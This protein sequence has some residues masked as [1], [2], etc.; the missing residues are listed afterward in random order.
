MKNYLT[1]LFERKNVVNGK[2]WSR[3]PKNLLSLFAQGYVSQCGDALYTAQLL[4]DSVLMKRT[5]VRCGAGLCLNCQPATIV[6]ETQ[7]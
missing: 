2:R 5:F 6:T 4:P 3:R 1:R 7:S